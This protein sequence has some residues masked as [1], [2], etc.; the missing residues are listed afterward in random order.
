MIDLRTRMD[1]LGG[2]EEA[3]QG[4]EDAIAKA[5]FEELGV[6]EGTFFEVGAR[7]GLS[8]STVFQPFVKKGWS[9]LL[10]E[11]DEPY[12]KQ[13]VE[14]MS[15]YPKV[16]TH[17]GKVTLEKG[18]T[19]DELLTKYGFDDLDFFSIDIDSYDYWIWAGLKR[20]PKAVCIEYN[21]NPNFIDVA[22]V[23]TYDPEYIYQ[24]SDYYGAS[25]K[26]LLAL[27][28]HKGYDCVGWTGAGLSLIFVRKDLNNGRFRVY[29]LNT[30][31]Y[32]GVKPQVHKIGKV[33]WI[34]DPK[35]SWE[36]QKK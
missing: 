35:F 22:R 7:D 32:W 13:L 16:K 31:E 2:L 36:E 15:P 23:I 20:Q 8:L 4:G 17:Q 6:E 34:Y 25:A 29:D 9:G 18:E 12:Y 10:V 14:N 1:R 27:G 21:G 5:I 26:A 28:E 33:E 24:S 19:V 30:I 11:C 3:S